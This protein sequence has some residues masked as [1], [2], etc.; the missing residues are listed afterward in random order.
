MGLDAVVYDFR[1]LE[2]FLGAYTYY[3]HFEEED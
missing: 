2:I 3:K 1:V